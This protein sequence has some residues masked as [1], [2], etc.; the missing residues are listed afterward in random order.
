MAKRKPDKPREDFSG[1]CRE[2]CDLCKASCVAEPR[3]CDRWIN[4]RP[5]VHV[6]VGHSDQEREA[7]KEGIIRAAS[8]RT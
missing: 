3:K 7:A 8:T 2:L 5:G 4:H 1:K 6:C